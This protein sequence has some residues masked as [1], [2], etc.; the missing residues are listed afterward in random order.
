[1]ALN[2]T[3]VRDHYKHERQLVKNIAL[4]RITALGERPEFLRAF[5]T[6]MADK[7]S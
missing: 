1:M 4:A 5:K 2:I 7:R 3:Q 6:H